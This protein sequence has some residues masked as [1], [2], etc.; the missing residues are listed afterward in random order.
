MIPDGYVDRSGDRVRVYVAH[1]G[2]V[3]LRWWSSGRRLTMADL[4]PHERIARAIYLA[5]NYKRRR[6]AAGAADDGA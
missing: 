1:Y 2:W 6:R 4:L 5:D 3:W